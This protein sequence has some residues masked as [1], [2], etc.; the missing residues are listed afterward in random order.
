LNGPPRRLRR[1]SR[2]LSG[3]EFF[4]N[5]A[6][7]LASAVANSS[8]RPPST[9]SSNN[10]P[11]LQYP[12]IATTCRRAGL[13]DKQ[14]A[15]FSL[16]AAVLLRDAIT[17]DL[18]TRA[19]QLDPTAEAEARRAVTLANLILPHHLA[20]SG[21]PTT[22]PLTM[23]LGGAAGRGKSRVINAISDFAA[24]W[25]LAPLVT[26][27]A[28][29]GA[30]A[31]VIGGSTAH[32]LIGLRTGSALDQFGD[33]DDNSAPAKKNSSKTDGLL[34]AT[35]LLIIDEISF[36]GAEMIAELSTRLRRR[37]PVETSEE[38]TS[39]T[40]PFGYMNL[41][42]VGDFSQLPPVASTS[43]YRDRATLDATRSA[44]PKLHGLDIWWT[45]LNACPTRE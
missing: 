3:I 34:S 37:C 33:H 27:S 18:L 32:S 11:L 14:A 7:P 31:T 24:A 8:D 10:P 40:H 35:R 30:A 16:P 12:T 44:G 15:A 23:Y 28:T 41:L 13:N 38:N 43:L 39:L 19:D 36:F 42:F 26:L 45:S 17:Q 25:G 9:A 29:T 5:A 1:L 21:E 20:A 2:P 6:P 4:R 22:L